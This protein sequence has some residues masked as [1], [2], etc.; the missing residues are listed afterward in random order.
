MA[1]ADPLQFRVP[2]PDQLTGQIPPYQK[3]TEILSYSL[4]NDRRICYDDR[5][6]SCYYEAPL[7]TCLFDRFETF[8]A[9][10]ITIN[11]HLDSLLLSLVHAKA[12]KT[13]DL[14]K[15]PRFVTFRGLLT[16]ILCLPFQN[17]EDWEL[18]ATRY[19]GTIYIEEHLTE[20]RLRSQPSTRKHKLLTYSGYRF[21]TVS[22][23]P[24]EPSD[25][26]GSDDPRLTERHGLDTNNMAEFNVVFRTKLGNHSI[27]FGA[28]IDCVSHGKH[29]DGRTDRYMEL[30]TSGVITNRKGRESFQR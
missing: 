3:P 21:E 23:I 25:I 12:T 17:R 28:E 5:G 20:A 1:A 11:E 30:K 10:D 19:N 29:K 14:T 26:A 24:V 6:L 15:Q 7:G 18:G 2:Y 4:D 16:R 9:R 8:K 22:T 13:L 27:L